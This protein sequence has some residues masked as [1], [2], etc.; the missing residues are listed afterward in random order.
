MHLR[1]VSRCGSSLREK[2]V[3]EKKK[4]KGKSGDA[5]PE[6]ISCWPLFPIMDFL[7]EKVKHKRLD[8]LHIFI[9]K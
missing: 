6:I 9:P 1:T 5:G 7:R 4:T 8:C 2:Y 3:R